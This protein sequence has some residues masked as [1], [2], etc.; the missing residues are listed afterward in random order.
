MVPGVPGVSSENGLSAQDEGIYINVPGGGFGG[1]PAGLPSQ[2]WSLR[3]HGIS[4]V[5]SWDFTDELVSFLLSLRIF[6]LYMWYVCRDACV[7]VYT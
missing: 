1:E 3:N 6:P 7:Y 4:H 2:T 5:K